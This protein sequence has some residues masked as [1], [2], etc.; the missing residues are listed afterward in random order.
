MARVG[1]ST[2][3]TIVH[4]VS[5]LIINNLWKD[6]V[7]AHFPSDVARFREK[8]LDTEQLWQSPCAWASIDGC[9][10]LLKCPAGGLEACKEYYNFKNFYSII[11]T[12]MVDAKYRFYMGKLRIP[13]KL[14]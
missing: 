1:V 9:H 2:V 6:S 11:L 10:L 12:G 8:M 7:M 14:S 4:E 3:C 5:E 13:W